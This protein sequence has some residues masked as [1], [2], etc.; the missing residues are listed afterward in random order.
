MANQWSLEELAFFIEIYTYNLGMEAS[1]KL[2][3]DEL[4]DRM[5]L[6]MDQMKLFLETKR[7]VS[8]IDDQLLE[9]I[10]NHPKEYNGKTLIIAKGKEPVDGK[11][12][13]IEWSL[14]K[15]NENKPKVLEDG[16]VDFYS[17]GQIANI[18]KGQLIA[19]RIR[20]IEGEPGKDVSGKILPARKGK[21]AY[22]KPGKNVVLDE[23]KNMVYAAIDGQVVI[24]DQDKIN[25]F[26]IYE[27]NGDVDFSIGNIDFFGTVVVRGNVPDG[28]KIHAA[29][30]IKIY[31]NVEGA[32][33]V[34]KG[35]ILIQ[36]G[37]LGHRKSFVQSDSNIKTS[38]ILD[39]KV[40]AGENIEVTQSIMHSEVSAGKKVICKGVKGLIVG[41]RIQAGES[42]VATSIGNQMATQTQIEVGVNPL[43]RK[44][45]QSIQK[46]K[47][48]LLETL[49]KVNK[50]LLLLDR[51]E[52]EGMKLPAEKVMMRVQL[53]KQQLEINNKLKEFVDREQELGEVY[54]SLGNATIEV[55]KAIYPGVKLMIGKAVKYIKLESQHLRFTLDEG[56]IT[57]RPL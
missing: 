5:T 42:V 3:F 43:L 13:Y 29:G 27:V 48:E 37:I 23:E 18:K 24:T 1:M 7:I 55:S 25:V 21:E 52:R 56:E 50:A 36:Q 53:L 2:K 15:N 12:G 10:C 19:K 45:L 39:G 30:D 46:G 6:N 17:I 4:N 28:F 38:Y 31:G 32:E 44:E 8:G 49:D 11:D 51:M 22:L 9:R 40:Q 26:P 34:A 33:L 16:R 41:G 57:F 35:D 20:A 54:K 47:E 14:A